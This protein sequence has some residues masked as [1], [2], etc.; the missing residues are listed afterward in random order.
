M[1]SLVRSNFD[2]GSCYSID[3]LDKVVDTGATGTHAK[4]K[5]EPQM[6]LIQV[7][8]LRVPNHLHT[9]TRN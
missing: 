5:R 8:S 4:G 7:C 6:D 3:L 9:G 2:G 1:M